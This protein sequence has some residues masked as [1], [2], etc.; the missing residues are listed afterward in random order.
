MY[1]YRFL[2]KLFTIF[3]VFSF[4]THHN[5]SQHHPKKKNPSTWS[6][7]NGHEPNKRKQRLIVRC[8]NWD[9]HHQ[10]SMST[11][12]KMIQYKIASMAIFSFLHSPPRITPSFW[13]RAFLKDGA[14][15]LS[16]LGS[17][18]TA[19]WF[20]PAGSYS[21]FDHNLV[22]Y[23]QFFRDYIGGVSKRSFH[24][25]FDVFFIR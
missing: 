16:S 3:Y 1:K 20:C 5:R 25:H 22:K 21:S 6:M 8:W 19:V 9:Q 10:L 24:P 4:F 14:I 7:V 17:H 13:E 18:F 12:Q 11:T 23:C 2:V 15:G